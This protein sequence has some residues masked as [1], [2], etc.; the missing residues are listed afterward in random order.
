MQETSSTANR[1]SACLSGTTSQHTRPSLAVC[2]EGSQSFGVLSTRLGIEEVMD[3][4]RDAGAL[5]QAFAGL[6]HDPAHSGAC[7]DFALA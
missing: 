5:R 6:S 4:A 7:R 2:P 1:L 3:R